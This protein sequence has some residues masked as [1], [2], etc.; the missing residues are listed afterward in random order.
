MKKIKLSDFV[1]NSS[2]NIGQKEIYHYTSAESLFHI[3]NSRVLRLC[4]TEYMNDSKELKIIRD[5]S[6]K[7]FLEIHNIPY[8]DK[9]VE[10]IKTLLN[11]NYESFIISFSK[12]RDLLSQWRDYADNSNGVSIGFD[13]D[14]LVKRLNT[15]MSN[16]IKLKELLHI[17]LRPVIYNTD[18]QCKTLSINEYKERGGKTISIYSTPIGISFISNFLSL[19][20]LVKRVK[21]V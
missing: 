12:H 2:E 8:E 21:F 16:S 18:T 3:I 15:L 5:L 7:T 13:V 19:R 10:E 14:G 11:E 1:F 4:S 20:A 9:R 6:D 17:G